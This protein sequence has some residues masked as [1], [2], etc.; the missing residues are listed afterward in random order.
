MR[1]TVSIIATITTEVH[2]DDQSTADD[3]AFWV[4]DQLF[5]L[6]A[7][8]TPGDVVAMTVEPVKEDHDKH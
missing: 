5:V 6:M 2:E 3:L 1:K 7:D 8:A 4:R